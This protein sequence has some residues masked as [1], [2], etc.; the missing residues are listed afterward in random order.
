MATTQEYIN[1]IYVI[2]LKLGGKVKD[3][4]QYGNIYQITTVRPVT[5]QNGHTGEES[6]SEYLERHLLI[7]KVNGKVEL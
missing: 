5:Y 1:D 4:T 6:T 3:V 7:P 2:L